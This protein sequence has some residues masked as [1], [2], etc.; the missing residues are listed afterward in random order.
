M[1]LKL[2][3][4]IWDSA[5]WL[6]VAPRFRIADADDDDVLMVPGEGF[7]IPDQI[8]EIKP[9]A[10]YAYVRSNKTNVPVFYTDAYI[11]DVLCYI[12][13][14]PITRESKSE[15]LKLFKQHFGCIAC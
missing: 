3:D 5:I 6:N 12:D 15:W 2:H 10:V 9:S 11:T 13:E 7:H 1:S 14:N 8:S 4:L